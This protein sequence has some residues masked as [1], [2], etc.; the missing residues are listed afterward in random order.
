MDGF[1]S[2]SVV[3]KIEKHWQ[4]ENALGKRTSSQCVHWWL[5]TFIL[6]VNW[7]CV[8]I[9]EG[10]PKSRRTTRTISR[11]T[12]IH[13]S[14]VYHIVRQHLKKRRA[15][16]LTVA[17]CW[18][19]LRRFAASAMDFIIFTDELVWKL[20]VD[21]LNTWSDRLLLCLAFISNWATNFGVGFCCVMFMSTAAVLGVFSAWV[22]IKIPS[23]N[24][25]FEMCVLLRISFAA[26][27][28]IIFKIG[29]QYTE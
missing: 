15:Q 28:P 5:A 29:Q 6:S 11:E 13:D 19:L 12:G 1:W 27:M 2:E 18:K 8:G 3:N 10:A 4:Y 17:N 21:I 9:R 26:V 24:I 20:V 14:S 22:T 7:F 25:K 16:K 23:I